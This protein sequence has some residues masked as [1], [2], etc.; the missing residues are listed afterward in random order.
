MIHLHAC[1]RVVQCR[2]S[3]DCASMFVLGDSYIRHR[4]VGRAS[5]LA[6]GFVWLA[7]VR[8]YLARLSVPRIW[9]LAII[10]GLGQCRGQTFHGGLHC[11]SR[12]YLEKLRERILGSIFSGPLFAS[13]ILRARLCNVNWKRVYDYTCRV[14]IK[15]SGSRSLGIFER[16]ARVQFNSFGYPSSSCWNFYLIASRACLWILEIHGGKETFFRIPRLES[17]SPFFSRRPR[18]EP[19]SFFGK[20]RLFALKITRSR[21]KR[22]GSTDEIPGH[23]MIL[24]FRSFY[25]RFEK[26]AC[27]CAIRNE[28]D[29]LNCW[30]TVNFSAVM[31]RERRSA[32]IRPL[33]ETLTNSYNCV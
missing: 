6:R 9:L 22:K 4:Q 30:W 26:V 10:C 32:R 17:F 5:W 15:G 14:V 28:G 8:K 25:E 31:D 12:V 24:F 19:P 23:D 27:L 3:R 33:N 13:V 7:R 29:A 21:L 20:W 1:N 2:N 18:I 11:I 16:I